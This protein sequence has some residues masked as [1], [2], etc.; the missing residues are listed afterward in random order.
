MGDVELVKVAVFKLQDSAMRLQT[1][2]K[3]A[4]S[5]RLRSRLLAMARQ[6]ARHQTALQT[7]S[8]AFTQ[9][10]SGIDL[11]EGARRTA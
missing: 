9:A 6:L 10:A 1:L 8:R 7:M 4:R 11:P 2:A 3:A 5:P